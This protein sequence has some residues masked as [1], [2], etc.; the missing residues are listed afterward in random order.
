MNITQWFTSLQTRERYLLGAGS[1]TLILLAL[2]LLLWE[3]LK[4][5]IAKLR[6]Q[7]N[8][9][10]S[11]LTWM[12]NAQ[13][14]LQGLK[15][16]QHQPNIDLKTSL[17]TAVEQSATSKGIRGQIKRIEPQG[18]QKISVELTLVGFD[19]LMTWVSFLESRYGTKVVQF[20]STQ[21]EKTGLVDA[22]IILTREAS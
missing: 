21:T 19:Q 14:E 10:G 7:D 5:D 18:Q 12:H 3:P 11:A 9:S 2:Y 4:T 20:H 8:A 1:I 15:H 17:I 22:R 13:T 6:V 16:N